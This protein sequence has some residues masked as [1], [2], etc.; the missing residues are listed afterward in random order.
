MLVWAMEDCIDKNCMHQTM[1]E[2]Q[3]LGKRSHAT[4]QLECVT[5]HHHKL[6]AD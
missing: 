2:V 1:H 5:Q 6:Q 4:L 3:G